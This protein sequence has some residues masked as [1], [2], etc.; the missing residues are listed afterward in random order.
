MR[1]KITQNKL[2]GIPTEVYFNPNMALKSMPIS[3][4]ADTTRKVI[5]NV[6]ANEIRGQLVVFPKRVTP[7]KVKHRYILS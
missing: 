1:I 6:L 3:M 5:L 2:D 7:L 4:P